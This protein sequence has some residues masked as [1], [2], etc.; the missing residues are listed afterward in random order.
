MMLA[1]LS[2]GMRSNC[3]LMRMRT[4]ALYMLLVVADRLDATDGHAGHRDGR[5]GLQA[6][7]VLELRHQLITL[8]VRWKVRGW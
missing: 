1:S 7:D 4:T 5:A 8:A 3:E 6:A 2:V